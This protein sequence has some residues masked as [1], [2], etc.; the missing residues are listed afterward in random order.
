[1]VIPSSYRKYSE[2]N[3]LR[4]RFCLDIIRKTEDFCSAY[5]P[6]QQYIAGF[7]TEHH[8]ELTQ[9]I[10]AAHAVSILDYKLNDIGDS[11]NSAL[12]HIRRW[13]Y[14]A[15]TYTPLLGNMEV[16]VNMAHTVKPELG[17]IVLVLTSNHEALHYQKGALKQGHPLYLAF[18]EDVKRCGA[19]GCVVGA[20]GH[21]TEAEIRMIRK[22]VGED[23]VFL[24]PGVGAQRGD[25]V[26]VIRA[27][28]KNLLINVGRNV[29]YSDDPGRTAEEYMTRFNE[30][31]LTDAG[32]PR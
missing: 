31:Y 16:T 9:A 32:T 29:I 23:T 25:P 21:V 30:I 2:E 10:R 6:N 18:A 7:S 22:T 3:E 13:G 27:S 24:V 4:L 19:D 15:V 26:K 11:I 14:D 5:K 1:M 28:G 20:T 8:Q 17:V 12:Y